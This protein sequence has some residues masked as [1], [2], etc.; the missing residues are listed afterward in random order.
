MCPRNA[1]A[2]RRHGVIREITSRILRYVSRAHVA[3]TWNVVWHVRTPVLLAL[4]ISLITGE[5]NDNIIFKPVY[6]VVSYVVGRQI[7]RG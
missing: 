6:F 4:V 3:S 1:T 2:R 5:K 7:C